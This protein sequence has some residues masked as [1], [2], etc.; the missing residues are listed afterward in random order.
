MNKDSLKLFRHRFIPME[1]IPLTDDEI[2]ELKDNLLVTRW[3][4]FHPRP[5]FAYGISA[6]F[7]DKGWKVSKICDCEG[8][9]SYWYCDIIESVIDEENNSYT[10]NDL[11]FDVVVYPNGSLKV[12]DCDEAADALEQGLISQEQLLYGLRAMNELL[13][14]IYHGRFDRLQAVIENIA[15]AP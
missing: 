9:L 13:Y 12:L 7:L 2:L 1:T 15:A 4:S 8:R 14:T 3:K 6:F 5:E 10:Y 11:L